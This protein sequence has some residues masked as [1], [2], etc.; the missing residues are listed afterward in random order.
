[1][2]REPGLTQVWLWSPSMLWGVAGTWGQ[3][4]PDS[5]IGG[6]PSVVEGCRGAWP[7]CWVSLGWRRVSRLFSETRQH[8]HACYIPVGLLSPTGSL[9][10]TCCESSHICLQVCVSFFH[11]L[12][13]LHFFVLFCFLYFTIILIQN[14]LLLVFI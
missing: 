10:R 11:F 5:R 7:T 9:A 2:A 12:Q 4:S 3:G 8:L 6:Q 14:L 13:G 1:M